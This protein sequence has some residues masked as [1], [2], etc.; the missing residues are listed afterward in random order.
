M[1]YFELQIRGRCA[2][3]WLEQLELAK[4]NL[5]PNLLAEWEEVLTSIELNDDIEA[6]V[7]SHRQ[8]DFSV[9]IDWTFLFDIKELGVWEKHG[10]RIQGLLQR[11]ETY[12]KPIVAA[13]NGDCMGIGVEL[14]LVCDYRLATVRSDSIFSFPSVRLGLLPSGG[15]TQRLPRLVGV[16]AALE[17]LVLGEE[18]NVY[19][20]ERMGLVDKLVHPY[21]LELVAQQQALELVGKKIVRHSKLSAL[22]KWKESTSIGRSM[23]LD[24]ARQK[25]HQYAYGNYP[26]LLK[27]I[28]CVAM[29]YKYG[30]RA[31]YELEIKGMD[32]MVTHPIAK[33]LIRTFFAV[34]EK[35]KNPLANQV[36][37]VS[38]IGIIGSGKMGE[39]IA[40]QS[41]V[42]GFE[43]ILSDLSEQTLAQVQARIWR[44]LA[45]LSKKRFISAKK[46][47]EWMTN[48]QTTTDYE[49]FEGVGMVLEAVFEDIDLKRQV[50]SDCMEYLPSN[51]IYAINT[52]SISI[53]NIAV[54]AKNPSQVIG[55]CYFPP[56][57]KS[58]LLE[59]V[60]TQHT[61]KSVIATAI[62]VGI[63]Q[64]KV[65]IVVKDSP[66]FY[67]TRL[68]AVLLNEALLLLE[69]GG[70]ILQVDEA[71]KQLGFSKGVFEL[72]DEVGIDVGGYIMSGTLLQFLRKRH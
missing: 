19:K 20:A 56:I 51:G 48:L 38:K 53:S 60:V 3:I 8:K 68:L 5:L 7:L 25:V 52:S 39:N 9:D 36:R 18:V 65:P 43:V 31:G 2:W 16:Q 46:Q 1:K 30:V 26:A 11:M 24:R 12:P 72:I 27:I 54:H 57:L 35:K 71:A 55:M 40:R 44:H 28:E 47:G 29:G 10:R 50:L 66:G 45:D 63:R 6:V 22:D 23:I 34:K 37:P 70:D 49:G 33:Q 15:G 69:E 14:A 32:E 13:I 17:M 41:L 62:D 67:T 61:A 64:G 4:E 58:S 21:Q 42:Q 59:I